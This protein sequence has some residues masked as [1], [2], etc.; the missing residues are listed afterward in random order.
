MFTAYTVTDALDHLHRELQLTDG[1]MGQGDSRVTSRGTSPPEAAAMRRQ[2]LAGELAGLHEAIDALDLSQRRLSHAAHNALR[3][4]APEEVQVR[5]C[6]DNQF[7]RDGALEWGDPTCEEIP[8]K[9]GLHEACYQRERRWR[10][11][12]G[13]GPR[14]TEPIAL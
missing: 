9:A 10:K 7:G 5:R 8:I 4:S 3:T 11:A 12:H 1:Y 2:A 6:R 14:E 13:L